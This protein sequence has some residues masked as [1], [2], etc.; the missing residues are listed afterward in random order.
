MQIEGFERVLMLAFSKCLTTCSATTE[1]ASCRILLREYFLWASKG[2]FLYYVCR[3]GR[4]RGF[5]L[6]LT[7]VIFI[8]VYMANIA[9]SVGKRV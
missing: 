8:M 4:G 3:G 5:V 6:L 7:L 2:S 9:Y 1:G